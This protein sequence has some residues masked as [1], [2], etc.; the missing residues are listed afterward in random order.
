MFF[1][2]TILIF[3]FKSPYPEVFGK[4]ICFNL[5]DCPLETPAGI[6]ILIL[7]CNV[8]ISFEQPNTASGGVISTSLIKLSPSNSYSLSLKCTTR[9]KSPLLPYASVFPSP[10][11]RTFF[12]SLTPLGSFTFTLLECETI[13]VPPQ[14]AQYVPP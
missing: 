6:L 10:L 5:K 2:T 3:A 4:P 13:P 11:R 7:P 12:P 1:G 9:Y 14:F 8:S